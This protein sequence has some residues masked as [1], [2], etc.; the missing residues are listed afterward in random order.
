[1]KILLVQ[2]FIKF[3]SVLLK[4]TLQILLDLILDNYPDLDVF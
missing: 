1:M 3:C 4:N 2:V